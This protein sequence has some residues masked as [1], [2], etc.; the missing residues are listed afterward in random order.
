MADRVDVADYKQFASNLRAADKTLARSIRK[1][2]KESTKELGKQIITEGSEPMPARGGLRSRLQASKSTLS[3]TASRAALVLRNKGV[4]LD[5]LNKGVLR[6][7]LFGHRPWFQQS[8]P[9]GTYTDAWE[10]H[11]DDIIEVF[12]DALDTAAKEVAR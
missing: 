2:V 10:K 7:P 11:K 8:V 4:R 12:S 5:A 6:H 9:E 3:L 1:A